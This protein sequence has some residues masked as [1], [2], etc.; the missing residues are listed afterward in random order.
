[1]AVPDTGLE[2]R[3]WMPDSFSVDQ[4][5]WTGA[6]C[7]MVLSAPAQCKTSR[8]SP[9][10]GGAGEQLHP[11]G[12]GLGIETKQNKIKCKSFS[13]INNR[14]YGFRFVIIRLSKSSSFD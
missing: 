10:L 4:W 2:N 14:I 11:L 7:P 8:T 9:V 5:L 6:T 13:F 12:L 1:M 3:G